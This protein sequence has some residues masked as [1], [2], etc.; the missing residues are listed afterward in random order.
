[1][2]TT[3]GVGNVLATGFR[4]WFKNI[5]P[6]LLITAIF[7]S[8]L[9]LWT[10]SM[11][12][13]TSLHD[14]QVFGALFGGLALPINILVTAALTYGVVMELQGRRAS[15]GACISIGIARFFPTLGVALLAMLCILLGALAL[16]V[17]A[18]VVY[19]MLYVAVPASVLERPGVTGALGRSRELTRGHKMEIF[20]LVFLLGL[21]GFVLNFVVGRVLGGS[22]ETAEQVLQ[23]LQRALMV[24]LATSMIT[25]SITATMSSVA[26][27]FL[28]SEK[29]GT[30]AAELAKIFD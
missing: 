23:G 19:C 27:Y 29:E 30:S 12:S 5:I 14:L 21:L 25:G 10:I 15:F 24:N 17:G 2:N 26:Y 18:V 11:G 8:P 1:M 4:V 22:A 9:W 7:Y 6:F 13:E 28:R 16:L 3:F 20:G